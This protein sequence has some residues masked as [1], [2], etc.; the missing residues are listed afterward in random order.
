MCLVWGI[1]ITR[2]VPWHC[3]IGLGCRDRAYAV[4]SGNTTAAT[5]PTTPPTKTTAPATA[6]DT[7][8]A[9][10]ATYLRVFLFT[11][12]Q[13]HSLGLL[14]LMTLPLIFHFLPRFCRP[15]YQRR[16]K[17]LPLPVT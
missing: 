13:A 12:E 2:L 11:Y 3:D 9:A 1:Y 5:T 8:L 14:L 10:A 16:S 4:C 17:E 6:T 7:V 15:A